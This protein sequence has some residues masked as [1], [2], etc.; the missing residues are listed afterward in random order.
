[1]IAVIFEVEPHAGQKQLY[2]DLAADLK[3][4]LEKIDVFISI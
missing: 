2:L 4:F 3:P 1:M